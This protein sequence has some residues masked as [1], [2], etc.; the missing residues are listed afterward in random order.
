MLMVR[1]QNA[2]IINEASFYLN[3]QIAGELA[4]HILQSMNSSP[5]TT[6]NN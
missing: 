4:E 2:I 6:N 3:M 1:F 5:S